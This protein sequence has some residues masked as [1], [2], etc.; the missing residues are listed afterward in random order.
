MLTGIMMFVHAVVCV[1]LV[2]V[3]LMQ[4]GRGGGL[5][6][7]F[8]SAESMFGA[9]TNE[10]MIKATTIFSA[11]FLVTCLGLAVLSSK[12]S[13]SLM[14]DNIAVPVTNTVDTTVDELEKKVQE[15]VEKA[16]EVKA[17]EPLTPEVLEPQSA[18]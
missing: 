8:S 7:S 12:K 2:I 14:S 10:L 5:T 1:L 18:E 13:E 9:Q 17:E 16:E 6:E 4:S 11:I 15:A 3:I